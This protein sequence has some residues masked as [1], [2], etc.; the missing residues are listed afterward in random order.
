ML[1]TTSHNASFGDSMKTH[2]VAIG[3]AAAAI[4]VAFI[5]GDAATVANAAGLVNK[6][7]LTAVAAAF[8]L[9]T[10]GALGTT[11]LI[12]SDDDF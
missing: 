11:L 9:I 12:D 4:L 10:V 2:P 6:A 1:N 7:Q 5:G 8:L 3:V